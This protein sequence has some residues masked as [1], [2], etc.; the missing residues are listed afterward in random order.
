MLKKTLLHLSLFLL[1]FLCCTLSGFEWMYGK[2]VLLDWLKEGGSFS[3]FLKTFSWP[4]IWEGRHFAIP[5]LGFLTFHEFGHYFAARFR[6]I[7]VSLPYYLPA[8]FGVLTSIGTFG[9]FIKIKEAVSTRKDYFD[10]AVAGPLSGFVIALFSLII[11]FSQIKSD[12][13]IFKVHPEYQLLKDDY[14][15]TLDKAGDNPNAVVLGE[16]LLFSYVKTH[17]GQAQFLPHKY[18]M[19]HYP[20]ILAGFLG[21]IFTAINL[22]PI[23]Q[24]DGGHILYCMVGKKVYNI[25]SPSFL[26]LVFAFSGMGF[27]KISDFSTYQENANLEVFL[28]FFIYVYFVY[29]TF[30]RIFKEKAN[31]FILALAVILVQLLINYFFPAFVGYSG[32]LFFCFLIGRFLG[33][34]HPDVENTEAIGIWRYLIGIL[35]FAIFLGSVSLYPI[36]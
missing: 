36:S 2:P 11:G 34:Y 5:F 33:V 32:I 29:I 15:K 16:S 26:V 17:Y 20:L 9:A 25:L 31:N 6:K 30:S 22:L 1:T 13:F 3:E 18:E 23:G 14:R 19:S 10:I 4:Q 12:E 7:S 35:S 28:K 21:L 8:W 27:F 24:L